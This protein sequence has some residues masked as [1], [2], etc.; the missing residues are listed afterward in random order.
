[1]ATGPAGPKGDTGD[2]GPTGPQGPA[3]PSGGPAIRA[4]LTP[5]TAVSLSPLACYA[6][7]TGGAAATSD[8]GDLLTG[9]LEN[10]SGD[11]V[12]PNFVIVIPGARNLSTQGGAVGSVLLCNLQESAVDLPSGW[13]LETST[14]DAP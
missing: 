13:Q 5:G 12:V 6:I 3:G 14:I 11:A 10:A 2:P 4:V 8:R 7:Y 1:G 9:W